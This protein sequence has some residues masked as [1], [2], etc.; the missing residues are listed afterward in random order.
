[1]TVEDKIKAVREEIRKLPYHKG[2]EHHIG[3]LKA[4]LA[5]LQDQLE[6][7]PSRGGGEGFAIK[8]SG[9]ATCVLVGFPSVGKSTLLN[10][11]TSAKSKVASYD[12]TTL[13]VIPGMMGYQGAQIQILDIPGLISGAAK[14]RG[15]GRQVI[16]VARGADLLLLMIGSQKP[17]QWKLTLNELYQAGIRVNQN[18]PKI[19]INKKEKGGIK[20]ISPTSSVSPSAVKEIA[21]EFRLT[22]AEI[23]I[24]ENLSLD[25]VI[26]FFS[27][28]R[29]YLPALLVVNKID[30]VKAANASEAKLRKELENTSEV[31]GVDENTIFV[32]A[33][34]ETGLEELKEKIWEKLALI[35]VYLK[36]KEGKPDLEKPLI[37]KR[38]QTLAD[39]LKKIPPHVSEGVTSALLWGSSASYPGQQIGLSRP[40]SDQDTITILPRQN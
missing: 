30:L 34:K 10:R 40:L 38:G 17:N 1:M 33:E 19:T 27:A 25:Q 18:P 26:D 16:S 7:K 20:V 32:S 6:K 29:V 13:T 39:A 4:K 14:G 37:I 2:T 35:R 9:D 23:I 36:P 21:K 12:F 31:K 8:K 5:R 24:K 28:N 15:H 11:L 22:N 3:R